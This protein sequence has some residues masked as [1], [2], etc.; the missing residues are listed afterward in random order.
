MKSE[1]VMSEPDPRVGFEGG[2]QK[3]KEVPPATNP[4]LGREAGWGS[5]ETLK[6]LRFRF[7][8][9]ICSDCP[10]SNPALSKFLGLSAPMFPHL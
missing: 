5:R 4:Q 2:R 8:I 1:V 3:K 7:K 9:I 6:G 10:R